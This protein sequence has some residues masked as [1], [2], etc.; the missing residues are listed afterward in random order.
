MDARAP[1]P[2][3]ER[4]MD[5]A[6]Q[7]PKRAAANTTDAQAAE[8]ALHHPEAYRTDAPAE[9]RPACSDRW[10]AQAVAAPAHSAEPPSDPAPKADP[11]EFAAPDALLRRS[12][13]SAHP[14]PGNAHRCSLA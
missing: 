5:A 7:E 12:P 4:T 14:T 10:L 2:D 8:Q 1:Q 6:A 13:A 11:C 9:A 3:V